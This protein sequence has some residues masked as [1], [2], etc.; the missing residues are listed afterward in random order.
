MQ[1]PRRGVAA[2]VRGESARLVAAE[3]DRLSRRAQLTE[4]EQAEVAETLSRLSSLLVLE[5][6]AEWQGDPRVVAELFG[7]PPSRAPREDNACPS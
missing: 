7:L 6:L 3:M 1:P 2:A 5:P 4:R